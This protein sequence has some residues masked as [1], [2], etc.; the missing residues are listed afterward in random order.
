MMT[1]E[2]AC[3]SQIRALGTGREIVPAPKQVQDDMPGHVAKLGNLFVHH[4]FWPAMLRKAAREC[5]G[6]DS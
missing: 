6:F 1:L 2:F 5:P 4:A 3:T